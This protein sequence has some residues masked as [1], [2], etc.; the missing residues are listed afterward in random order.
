MLF[1]MEQGKPQILQR[2]FFDRYKKDQNNRIE[3][4][5]A[6]FYDPAGLAKE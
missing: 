2:S 5:D 4:Q 1:E 6:I 3:G